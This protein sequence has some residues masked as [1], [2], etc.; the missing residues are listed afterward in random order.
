MSEIFEFSWFDSKI[1]NLLVPKTKLEN[2]LPCPV[3]IDST[4]FGQLI[5]CLKTCRKRI[6]V[7]GFYFF[8]TSSE[9]LVGRGFF[10]ENGAFSLQMNAK[11]QIFELFAP[12]FGISL[13]PKTKL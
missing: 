10:S 4:G 8:R 12:N 7:F 13:I 2:G 6:F 3:G 1:M 9:K 11:H 5:G